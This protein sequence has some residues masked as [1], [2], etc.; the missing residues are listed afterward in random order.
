MKSNELLCDNLR[1]ETKDRKIHDETNVNIRQN[2][3]F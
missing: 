2:Q 3:Q 1:H